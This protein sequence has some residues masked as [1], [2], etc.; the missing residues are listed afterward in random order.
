MAAG[1][2]TGKGRDPTFPPS[3]KDVVLMPGGKGQAA[4]DPGR[5]QHRPVALVLPAT[6]RL[7]PGVMC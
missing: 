2:Q 3:R 6:L 4:G 1:D 7:G 5:Y